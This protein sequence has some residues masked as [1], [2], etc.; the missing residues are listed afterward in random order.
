MLTHHIEE[1]L[2]LNPQR[3]RV[4]HD[5]LAAAHWHA[6]ERLEQPDDVAGTDRNRRDP[7]GVGHRERHL[8]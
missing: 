6:S 5:A 8:T 4:V 7:G 3:L 1:I 2:A